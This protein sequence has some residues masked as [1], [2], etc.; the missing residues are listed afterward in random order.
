MPG[1]TIGIGFVGYGWIARVHAH[2]LHTLNHLA[3]LPRR[4]ELVALAGRRAE[5]AERAARELG[6]ARWTTSWEAVVTDPAVDVLANVGPNEIHA[7]PSIA[8][9]ELGKPV[10][11]EKPLG[12]DL[13]EAR[14]MAAAAQSAAVTNA[15]GF[16]YR[17]VPAVRLAYETIASGRLGRLRHVRAV[18]LQDW[19]SAPLASRPSHG[20]SGAVGDYSHLVDL[21]LHLGVRPRAVSAHVASFVG[22]REDAYAAVLELEGGG[23]G[24]LEASRCATGW[25]GRQRIEL[26]GADG[27]LWWDMEDLNRLRVFFVSDEREGLGGFRDVLVTQPH[28]PFLEEWWTPGHSLGWDASFVHEWREF[29]RAVLEERPVP[30]TQASFEDGYRAAVVCDAILTAAREGRRIELPEPVAVES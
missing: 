27:A 11:C 1:E 5:R 26:N 17:F 25:K 7:E 21:L 24:V 6:F 4:V 18:Y 2:A 28:H 13:D 10:L 16:N 12:A 15:C 20:G 3:P 29:L 23:L 14:R 19:A 30:E 22:A 9:L 8:A